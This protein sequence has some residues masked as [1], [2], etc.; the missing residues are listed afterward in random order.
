MLQLRQDPDGEA[1]MKSSVNTTITGTTEG[2][3]Q[4]DEVANLKL[5]I[6]RL[7]KRLAEVMSCRHNYEWAIL[8]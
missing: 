7:E 1:A 3:D 6:S 8:Y 2:R 4:S 5:Q